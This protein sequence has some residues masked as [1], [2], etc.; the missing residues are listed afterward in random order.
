MNKTKTSNNKTFNK[1]ILFIAL[2]LFFWCIT[3]LSKEYDSTVKYPVNYNNLPADKLLQN[4]PVNEIDIHIKGTGF[5]IISAKIFPHKLE[6]DAS[7]LYAKSAND[8]YLLL[9]QQR[10]AL[11]R[12][13]KTGVQIDHFIADSLKFNL[14]LLQVKMI[15]IKLNSKLS[16]APGFELHDRV[17]I[18][19]DSIIVN[20]PE[21]ILDTIHFISTEMLERKELNSSINEEL[22]LKNFD[23]TSNIN[24][25]QKKVYV[26]ALVEKF[27]EGT[28]DIPFE[29]INLPNNMKI[30]TFPK[31]IKITYKV[32]LSNFNEINESSFLIQCDYKMSQDN[33]LSYLI[34]K[35]V[36]KS[37]MTKNIRMSP[38]KI[39]FIINK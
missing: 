13:M 22:S 6:L 9:S 15:P 20:G 14:G 5:K 17:K 35:I 4:K 26:T 23:L 19:P 21:S 38:N 39:D 10:L 3:K 33:N 28:L 37:T 27:T 29:V 30:N 24:F 8:Y 16:F 12:Q 7:N 25:E 34:P 31:I 11:Q 32:A 36:E 18:S 1:F 2:S